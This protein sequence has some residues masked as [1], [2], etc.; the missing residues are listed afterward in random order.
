[1]TIIT[2]EDRELFSN[3]IDEINEKCAK[4]QAANSVDEALAAVKEIGFPVIVRAAYAL[5]GLGS[6]F[7]NNEKELV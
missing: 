1:D 7:A 2:M 6:G 4:S 5:G 3:A